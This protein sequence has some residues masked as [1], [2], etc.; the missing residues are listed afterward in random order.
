MLLFVVHWLENGVATAISPS[1]FFP[2]FI[3]ENTPLPQRLS[4]LLEWP[5]SQCGVSARRDKLHAFLANGFSRLP[6]S[7]LSI[8]LD[9]AGTSVDELSRD[10]VY[11]V[12]VPWLAKRIESELRSS[13][14]PWSD[15]RQVGSTSWFALRVDE[16]IVLEVDVDDSGFV[17]AIEEL[18]QTLV[19]NPVEPTPWLRG[20]SPNWCSST[21]SGEVGGKYDQRHS[22]RDALRT[23]CLVDCMT[24]AEPIPLS[25]GLDSLHLH[26]ASPGAERGSLDVL[27]GMLFGLV[28]GQAMASPVQVSYRDRPFWFN[29]TLPCP[30][31]RRSRQRR[32]VSCR[33]PYHEHADWRAIDTPIESCLVQ[34]DRSG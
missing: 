34:F 5:C 20:A 28:L 32:Y 13:T 9:M 31:A 19:Q 24:S 8:L 10:E 15:W 30:R 2:P 4:D 26:P 29:W 22:V 6:S 3:M 11:L 12:D 33:L 25:I 23:A 17:E 18:Y 1:R 14:T 7:W 21:P 27:A 16:R